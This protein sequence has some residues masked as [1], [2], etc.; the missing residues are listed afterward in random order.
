M[1]TEFAFCCRTILLGFL[2]VLQIK[3]IPKPTAC[4]LPFPF[5]HLSHFFNSIPAFAHCV[6]KPNIRQGWL[7]SCSVWSHPA[8][9]YMWNKLRFPL[10]GLLVPT[11]PDRTSVSRLE[12]FTDMHFSRSKWSLC[13]VTPENTKPSCKLQQCDGLK[14]VWMR[15]VWLNMMLQ[16]LCGPHAWIVQALTTWNRGECVCCDATQGYQSWCLCSNRAHGVT[17]LKPRLWKN[18]VINE[19]QRENCY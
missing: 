1:I 4:A 6:N 12:K 11:E 18:S 8:Q 9:L 15:T 3:P 19:R 17:A 10:S 14:R 13:A 7:T 5:F 16:C 2:A